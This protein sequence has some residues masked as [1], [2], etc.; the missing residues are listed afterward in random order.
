MPANSEANNFTNYYLLSFDKNGQRR[1]DRGVFDAALDSLRQEPITDVF[2]FSHGWLVDE[3]SALRSYDEWIK[4]MAD[5]YLIRKAEILERRPGFRPLLIGLHWPSAPWEDPF[6]L[7]SRE[8]KVAFYSDLTGDSDELRSVL[9]TAEENP[10]PQKLSVETA[11]QLYQIHEQSGLSSQQVGA[12]P[13]HDYENY[14]P[15]RIFADFKRNARIIWHNSVSAQ[16]FKS[17][18]SPLWVTTFWKMK[19]RALQVGSSG[20]HALLA[21]LQAAAEPERGV[22]FHLIGHSF[23]GI[24]CSGSLQGRADAAPLRYPIYSLV[25]LQGA[26][27]LW[28]FAPNIRDTGRSGYF[29]PVVENERVS[30]SIITTQSKHDHALRWF[31]R[32]VAILTR[33]YRLAGGRKSLPRYGAVGSYGLAGLEERTLNLDVR[34]GALRYRIEPGLYYNFEASSVISGNSFSPQGAHS[35]VKRSELAGI[36]W[37]AATS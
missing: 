4:V 19:N 24:V 14:D 2:I 7:S 1:D 33:N 6:R 36:V 16:P 34:Q 23:G 30:G 12:A 9:A 27:S 10:D 25:L 5:Y 22:R 35:E 8:E 32:A 31:Y 17:I 29:Y 26:L 3:A 11:T 20:V 13:G 15:D 37:E 18:L 28:S 21:A